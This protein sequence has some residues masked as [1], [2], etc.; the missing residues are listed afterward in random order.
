MQIQ[1]FIMEIFKFLFK[2]KQ[3]STYFLLNKIYIWGI[4][5]CTCFITYIINLSH[6]NVFSSVLNI[7]FVLLGLFSTILHLMPCPRRLNSMDIII[8]LPGSLAFSLVWPMESC[9]GR[10]PVWEGRE[11]LRYLCP[12]PNKAEGRQRC[13]PL[14]EKEQ[15]EEFSFLQH[16]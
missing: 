1:S 6:T 3:I 12:N 15:L 7:L 10:K 11:R 14:V 4:Y 5:K 9:P 13:N 2:G 16:L 8:R